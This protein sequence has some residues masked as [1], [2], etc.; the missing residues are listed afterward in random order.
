MVSFAVENSINL[1]KV[2]DYK[3]FMKRQF[4]CQTLT[5]VELML[6]DIETLKRMINEYYEGFDALFMDA[7]IRLRRILQ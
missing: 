3:D 4:N 7:D 2:F 5:E 6:V 1:Q